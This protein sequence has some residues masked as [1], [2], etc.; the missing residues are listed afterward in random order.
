MQ[1]NNNQHIKYFVEESGQG[2]P[3]LSITDKAGERIYLHS[4]Y[5]PLNES[6]ILADKFIPEKFDAIIIL[7]A[8][9]G[10]HLLP[11]KKN[12]ERYK[13]III[14]DAI[15]NIET[16]IAKN[17]ETGF[18]ANS[19]EIIFLT[20][21]TF[22]EIQIAIDKEIDFNEIKGLDVIEHPSSA[23]AFS[24]Y[25]S[26][27]KK[28]IQGVINKKAG[29]IAT[30]KAFS[31]L[32]LRNIFKN[33]NTMPLLYPISA[34]FGAMKEYPVLIIAS[35]PSI[36][37][38][39]KMIKACQNRF[40]IIAVDSAMNTL[41]KSGI[42]PDFFVSIDPQPF[43]FEHIFSLDTG[44]TIPIFT[45]SSHPLMI[46][47]YKG[48]QP[49]L[50][51]N[52]HPFSQ[53]IDDLFPDKIGSIDSLSGTVAGDA[54]MAAKNFGYKIAGIIGFDFS[55]PELKIYPRGTAYQK[56]FTN[57]STRIDPVETINFKYI[58]KSS[59][60]VKIENK[61]TRKS[62]I[63]YKESIE[64]LFKKLNMPFYNINTSGILIQGIR[65]SDLKSFID[66]FCISD[67]NKPAITGKILST[68]KNTGKYFFY[69]RLIELINKKNIFNDIIDA[70]LESR[71]LNRI[72]RL[73][74][75]VASLLSD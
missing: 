34:F 22:D 1:K 45:I 11:L 74:L 10:Y 3:T 49:L 71:S 12:W 40:F 7:G 17:P 27:I 50:S 19:K 41:I 46:E 25:Y 32:Y 6:R 15:K 75:F 60:G 43:I 21:M 28:I 48:S 13:K 47:R 57:I 51:L 8:G 42:T 23:R 30:K 44:N 24:G 69:K 54:I 16:E 59:K 26:N 35:G 64:S 29:N 67:I 18:L 37:N 31:M 62:F 61:Y 9:L 53:I 56:R 65:N 63:Q 38:Y 5:N 73:R 36:E 4:K 58:M 2:L 66:D 33:L 20:G 70:S 14:I 72:E 52:T 39:I 68:A 55:F